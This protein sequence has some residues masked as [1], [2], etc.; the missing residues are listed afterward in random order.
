MSKIIRIDRVSLRN[1]IIVAL[2]V[3]SLLDYSLCSLRVNCKSKM[4]E[5]D[6]PAAHICHI[7]QFPLSNHKQE[8]FV[9]HVNYAQPSEIEEVRIGATARVMQTP[10]ANNIE[11]IP[12]EI[13]DNFPNLCYFRMTT[14][15]RELNADDFA[16]AMNLTALNLSGNKL[17]LIKSNI[18]SPVAKLPQ[19]SSLHSNEVGRMRAEAIVPLHKLRELSL[20]RNEISD[21]EV[22]SFNGLSNLLDVNLAG[23]QLTA[24][25]RQ[26]FAGMPSLNYLNLANNKI[27]SIQDGALELP[28]LKLLNLAHNKLTRLSDALF[29]G[30]P[31]LESIKM[32]FNYLEYIGHAFSEL[33]NVAEIS[34]DWNDIQD[35]DLA[36]F[37]RLPSLKQLILTQS[38]F[39]FATTKV[40]ENQRWNSPLIKLN[41]GGNYLSNAAEL[42]KL[43]IFPNLTF[44]VLSWNTFADLDVGGGNRT[45]KDILPSL[46]MLDLYGNRMDSEH[47]LEI[48][49]KL[50]AHNV[51]VRR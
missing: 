11:R 13:F 41:I 31:K 46:E 5:T 29:S 42:N 2:I 4:Y 36:A 39:T 35:I 6:E 22:N 47:L 33:P 30:L 44:L 40:E 24:I 14:N 43:K 9:F 21:I 3:L 25:R 8:T 50:N 20:E 18:L 10:N 49:K 12:S 1:S 51:E 15:L 48:E 28:A 19:S 32:D 34:L 45:I 38:G 27:E 23:N 16:H 7:K 26:S 17:K 37:A